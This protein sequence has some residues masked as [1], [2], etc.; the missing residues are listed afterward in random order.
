LLG[1]IDRNKLP[2][3]VKLAPQY[4]PPSDQKFLMV[5]ADDGGCE[6]IAQGYSPRTKFVCYG[7]RYEPTTFK[8]FLNNQGPDAKG[9]FLGSAFDELTPKEG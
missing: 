5:P 6:G 4:T 2:S 8:T 3:D 7:T 9:L 1:T